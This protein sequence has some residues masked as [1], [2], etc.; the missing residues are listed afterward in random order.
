MPSND[1]LLAGKLELGFLAHLLEKYTRIDERVVVGP[2]VGVDAT[3]IDVG[4]TYLIAKTDPITFVT[5]EIGFYGIIINA[6]DIACMGGRPRWFLAT[7][8]LPE[9]LT[10]RVIVEEIFAQLSEACQEFGIAFCGGHTEVTYGINR[11]IVVG[12]ML[13]EVEKDRL[14]TSSGVKVGDEIV[15]TKGIAVEATSII[16]R[17]KE[18][19]LAEAYSPEL[20]AKCKEFIRKPGISVLKDA[21]LALACG[22]IHAM[23]DPTEGGI[24][25]GLFELAQASGVGLRIEFEEIPIF[26]ETKLLCDHYGLDPLGIIA[27][28][29]L[30]IACPS[31]AASQLVKM[32]E[33]VDI[34]A[35]IIGKA[36]PPEEGLQL[37]VEG[38]TVQWPHY[39]RDEIVK[40]F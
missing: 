4:S 40:I 33:K 23:H 19:E 21:E 37:I 11:P 16:A 14:I 17:E 24:A 30:L 38:E 18:A 28:G 6:N 7:I 36:I 12:Q 22:E 20:V 35:K 34:R 5:K 1:Y 27:S 25:T 32:L 10:T 39:P 3:V 9:G 2:K 8:L 13:G 26:A 31:K 29:A 15:V